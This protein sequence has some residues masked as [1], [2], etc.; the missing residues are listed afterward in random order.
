MS[1]VNNEN[2]DVGSCKLH[3]LHSYHISTIHIIYQIFFLDQIFYNLH[4]QV[5]ITNVP[6][7][8]LDL[9]NPIIDIYG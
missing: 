2:V 6:C 7:I 8:H 1:L 4:V 3:K 9:G 5:Q